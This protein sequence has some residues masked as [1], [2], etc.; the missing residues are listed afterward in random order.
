MWAPSLEWGRSPGGV[1]GNPLQ[2]SYQ[3]NPMDRGAWR[4]TVHEIRVSPDRTHTPLLGASG[5]DGSPQ[6]REALHPSLAWSISYPQNG[7]IRVE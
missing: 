6:T 1:S 3:E 4:A 2:Y 7:Y 5:P